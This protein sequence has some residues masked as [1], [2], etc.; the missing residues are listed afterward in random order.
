MLEREEAFA[1]GRIWAE[2]TREH[3]FEPLTVEG[4]LPS[5]LSGTLYRNGPGRFEVSGQRVPHPFD[6]DGAVDAIRI[7]GGQAH[8]ALRMVNNPSLA[9]ESR[10]GRPLGGFGLKSD[11][12]LLDLLRRRFRN[13]ANTSVLP[14]QGRLFALWEAGLP[15]EV[16]PENLETLGETDLGIIPETFSAHPHRHPSGS[17][18]LSLIHI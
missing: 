7:S 8:H 15:T 10:L 17:W 12:P 6:G 11:R 13:A 2:V 4:T 14:W 18:Y 16:D 5:C 9:V 3:G 1:G